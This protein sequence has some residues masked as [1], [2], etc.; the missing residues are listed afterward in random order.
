MAASPIDSIPWQAGRHPL[1]RWHPR[2][3]RYA[4]HAFGTRRDGRYF[5][6]SY[7]SIS[8]EQAV[9][10]IHKACDVL[11]DERDLPLVVEGDKPALGFAAARH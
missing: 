5:V 4:V 6:E 2:H 7:D 3:D 8:R 1:F 9:A 10:V 11:N